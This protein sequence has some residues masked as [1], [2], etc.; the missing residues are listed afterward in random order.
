[1]SI[2]GSPFKTGNTTAVAFRSGKINGK[3]VIRVDDDAA[4]NRVIIRLGGTVE[5]AH[6]NFFLKGGESIEINGDAVTSGA[7]ITILSTVN[8]PDIYWGII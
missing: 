2:P 1:M 6:A 4:T 5:A 8:D 3:L 7:D